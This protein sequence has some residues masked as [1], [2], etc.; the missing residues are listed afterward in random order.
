LGEQFHFVLCQTTVTVKSLGPEQKN[1]I[2][3]MTPARAE[4]LKS[5]SGGQG[6]NFV[7]VNFKNLQ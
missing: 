4:A 3:R 1:R 2:P 7:V 5:D 6:L